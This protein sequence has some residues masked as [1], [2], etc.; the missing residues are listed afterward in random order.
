MT[1]DSTIWTVRLSAAAERDFLE[2]LRWT[3]DRFGRRQ[4]K[5]YARVLGAALEAL[6]SGP[7]IIGVRRRDD[8]APGL[9]TLHVART[10]NKGRHFVLFRITPNTDERTIDVLRLLHDSMDI[11][12]HLPAAEDEMGEP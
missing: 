5:T 3:A 2:I 6:V 8:I 9:L 12:R 7:T 10:G 1:S 11:S 4:A